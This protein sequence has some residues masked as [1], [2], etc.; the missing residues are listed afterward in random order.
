MPLLVVKFSVSPA[1]KPVVI[2]TVAPVSVLLLSGVVRNSWLSRK[3]GGSPPSKVGVWVA[4]LAFTL[5]AV[6]TTSSVLVAVFDGSVG[7][8]ACQLMVRLVSPPP[9][10]GSPLLGVKTYCT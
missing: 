5:G 4:L 7:S 9:E 6:C 2:A 10:V 3:T 8:A 1:V